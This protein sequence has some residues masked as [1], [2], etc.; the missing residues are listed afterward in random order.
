MANNWGEYFAGT[1]EQIAQDQERRRR[2]YA[3][4]SGSDS[5]Q[6]LRSDEPVLHR[7]RMQDPREIRAAA[8]ADTLTPS[9]QTDFGNDLS[10]AGGAAMSAIGPAYSAVFETTMRP[11]DTLIK[12]G[13]AFASGD[14]M[15]GA[16][17]VARA[18]LSAVYPAAAAGTPG[19]PD[20]WRND[21]RSLGVPESNIMG[22]DIL[23]DPETYLPIP[24]PFVAAGRAARYARPMMRSA[25]VF[26]D[27]GDAIRQ[28]RMAR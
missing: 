12:A 22:I 20:D 25:R 8:I 23:T 9:P 28:L 16:S 15:R 1:P 19:S 7:G 10:A 13:Q 5:Y 27:A 18:P 4:I 2:E 11:R 14:P 17:L 21:A 6:R 3:R 26:D 24:I